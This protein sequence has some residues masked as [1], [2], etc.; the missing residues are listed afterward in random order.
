[1]RSP[2]GNGNDTIHGGDGNDILS[3]NAGNDTIYGEDGNDTINGNED[4]DWLSGGLGND[5]MEGASGNDTMFGGDG[6][7]ELHGGTGSGNMLDC[8]AGPGLRL[9]RSDRGDPHPLQPVGRTARPHLRELCSAW[10]VCHYLHPSRGS[11]WLAGQNARTPVRR[12]GRS[13]AALPPAA[14][15][16]QWSAHIARA[17]SA[18]NGP[19]DLALIWTATAASAALRGNCVAAEVAFAEAVCNGDASAHDRCAA[20]ARITRA[21]CMAPVTP[22]R[23]ID[24]ARRALAGGGAGSPAILHQARMALIAGH[25]AAGDVDVA[26]ALGERLLAGPLSPLDRGAPS[27]ARRCR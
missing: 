15:S 13:W 27:V 21:E 19:A 25:R 3:G 10:A 22:G 2:A 18:S 24:D 14:T 16:R 7:D 8:G 20:V 11:G 26:V 5:L 4:N 1:M 9:R 17:R 12:G 6:N 23:S